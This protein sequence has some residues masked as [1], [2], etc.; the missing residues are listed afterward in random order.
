MMGL[1]MFIPP[2]EN[3]ALKPATHSMMLINSLLSRATEAYWEEFT[4]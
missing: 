3:S 1:Y 4:S 2:P